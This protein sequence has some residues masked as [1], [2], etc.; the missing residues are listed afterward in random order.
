L[1]ALK[2]LTNMGY[3]SSLLRILLTSPRDTGEV[4]VVD[5][6]LGEIA[7]LRPDAGVINRWGRPKASEGALNLP[8]GICRMGEEGDLVVDGIRSSL[9]RFS[10]SGE[11]EAVY[12]TK[13]KQFLDLRGLVSAA[14]DPKTG[15]RLCPFQSTG[16]STGCGW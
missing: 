12:Y 6:L 9:Q 14:V 16:R 8:K 5:S 7:R 15:E 2:N 1:I 13:D 3:L 11:I 10:A 4:C